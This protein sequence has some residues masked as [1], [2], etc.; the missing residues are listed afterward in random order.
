MKGSLYS[1]HL[2]RLPNIFK[3]YKVKENR[4]KALKHKRPLESVEKVNG[5]SLLAKYVT[6]PGLCRFW[7]TDFTKWTLV[8]AN[9]LV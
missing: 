2:A 3:A 1:D 6:K 7:L 5:S 9:A 8:G 4:N